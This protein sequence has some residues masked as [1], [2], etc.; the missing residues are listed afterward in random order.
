MA[1]AYSRQ[2]LPGRFE[3]VLE[4]LEAHGTGMLRYTFPLPPPPLTH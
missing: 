4:L 2:G 1:A 3:Q